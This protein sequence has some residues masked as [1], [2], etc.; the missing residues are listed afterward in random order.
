MIQIAN[1]GSTIHTISF[2]NGESRI[3]F[4]SIAS[5]CQD[6]RPQA[7]IMPP[8]QTASVSWRIAP[9]RTGEPQCWNTFPGRAGY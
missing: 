5:S 1:A 8:R 4:V 3:P 9:D 7:P 2:P 6:I